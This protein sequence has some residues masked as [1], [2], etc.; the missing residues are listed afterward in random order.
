MLFFKSITPAEDEIKSFRR[1]N[2]IGV[3]KAGL[4][5][6]IEKEPIVYQHAFRWRM[7]WYGETG[8]FEEEVRQASMYHLPKVSDH[9]LT[10][11]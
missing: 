9:F 3:F 7:S 5:F 10:I 4:D 1:A 8:V 2:V 6:L 11:T